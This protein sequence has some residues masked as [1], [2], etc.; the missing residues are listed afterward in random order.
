MGQL[1]SAV[2]W[3][4]SAGLAKWGSRGQAM[5]FL[6]AAG[7]FIFPLTQLGL[8]MIGRPGRVSRENTLYSLGAQVAFVLPLSLPVVG[9][10]AL[11]RLDW[12]FPA[13]MVVPGA[14]YLPYVFLYGM[15]MFAVLAAV[16][17]AL[18]LMLG[19]G[20]MHPSPPVHGSR[21]LSWPC[22]RYSA[23]SWS[24]S[25]RLQPSVVPWVNR[26]CRRHEQHHA[27][28]PRRRPHASE[29]PPGSIRPPTPKGPRRGDPR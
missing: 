22:S 4:I 27:L 16:L 26:G 13:F 29:Y 10:A 19:C 18:G 15:R 23:A 12:F 17:W 6:V 25:R 20:S 2:L 3:G 1:V 5:V 11:H 14:H 8:R 7:M 28:W 21:R 24:S 9:A